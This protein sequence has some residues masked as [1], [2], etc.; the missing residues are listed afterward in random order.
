MGE[1]TIRP[2]TYDFGDRC[3]S[4][5]DTSLNTIKKDMHLPEGQS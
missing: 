1:G 4:K 3:V 2:S 5:R